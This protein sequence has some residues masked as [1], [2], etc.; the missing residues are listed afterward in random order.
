MLLF[1]ISFNSFI[2]FNIKNKDVAKKSLSILTYNVKG[3][4]FKKDIYFDSRHYQVVKFVEKQDPDIVVFQE[5][6]NYGFEKYSM[7]PYSFLGYRPGVEKSLQYVL[8]KYPIVNQG[9]IDFPNTNNNAMFIDVDYHEDV[10]R[11]Y[12]LHLESFRTNAIH[13]LNNSDSY[14]PLITRIRAAEKARK[15]QAELVNKHSQQFD[16][17]TIICG[18][19]NCTQFSPAYTTLKKSRKDTFVEA[20][21][22][23]GTTYKLF[24]YP[25]RLDYVLVDDN[26]EV[27]SHQNFNL[28][29]S[30]HE[31]VLARLIVN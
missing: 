16:G 17:K 26:F 13:Q 7:Y 19:F 6:W 3:T 5:F 31:P 1:F 21:F 10:I 12:N 11:I 29:L 24:N 9:Y 20:G 2:Q 18:D 22:G 8:S 28:K 27:I 23:I 15:T 14:L 25:F 30:D 4:D